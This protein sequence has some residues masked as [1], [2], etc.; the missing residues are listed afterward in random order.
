MKQ[1]KRSIIIA[2]GS[3]NMTKPAEV[4]CQFKNGEIIP[5]RFRIEDEFKEWQTFTVQK[6]KPAKKQLETHRA[7]HDI[8]GK[9]Q[10]PNMLEYDCKIEVLG[11]EKIVQL[12][13]FINEC[14]WKVVY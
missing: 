11:I 5:I 13:Y 6:Y 9:F 14:Q 10:I 4:I 7:Y 2:L 8:G 3:D 1:N 12:R